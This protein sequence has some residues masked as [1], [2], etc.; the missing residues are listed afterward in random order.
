MCLLITKAVIVNYV[1]K[2]ITLLIIIG[3]LLFVLFNL[4]QNQGGHGQ[5][6][7]VGYSDLLNEAAS[8]SVNDVTIK[9]DQIVGHTKDGKA[10]MTYVPRTA[11]VASKLAAT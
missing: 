11:D 9:G 4:F 5:S 6:S 7:D 8:G 1:G 3:V 10:F 2:N